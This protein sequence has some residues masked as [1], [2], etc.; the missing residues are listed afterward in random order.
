MK[1]C[2]SE[3]WKKARQLAM[4]SFRAFRRTSHKAS[5]RQILRSHSFGYNKDLPTVLRWAHLLVAHVV[6]G[7]VTKV[8]KFRGSGKVANNC[9]KCEIFCH[10]DEA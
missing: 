1:F 2:S 3:R 10:C 5:V 9:I 8:C 6:V 7:T 4:T